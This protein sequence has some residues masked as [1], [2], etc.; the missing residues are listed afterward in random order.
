MTL[1]QN[2]KFN[3]KIGLKLVSRWRLRREMPIIDVGCIRLR[4]MC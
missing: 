2:T 4:R 1:S 3:A